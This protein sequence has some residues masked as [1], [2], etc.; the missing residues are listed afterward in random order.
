MAAGLAACSSGNADTASGAAQSFGAVAR[1]DAAVAEVDTVIVREA[2]FSHVILSNGKL[3]ARQSAELRF[4]APGTVSKVFVRNGSRLSKGD[5]VATLATYTLEARMRQCREALSR[6]SLDMQDVIIGQGYDP[7]AEVPAAVTALARTRSGYDAAEAALDLCGK[8]LEA[9]TLRAPFDG[10][11][12]NLA[13]RPHSATPASEPACLLIN[14]SGMDV[15][16][17]VLEGELAMIA[18]GDLVEVAPVSGAPAAS[19]KVVEINPLVDAGGQISVKAVIDGSRDGFL[20]GMNARVTLRGNLGSGIAV[21]KSAVVSR[22]GR[23][24]VFT[25]G[26]GNRAVWNYVT[27]G[28]ENN[29]SFVIDEGL[30]PGACVIVSGN[31]TLAHESPVVLRRRP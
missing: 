8:E 15:E 24:V 5:P 7:G 11:V 14:D 28:A 29:T 13:L 25:L 31:A 26:P 19:G 16:F 17:K 23:Q 6:A 27:T 12:A 10:V 22:S 1:D 30:E 3:H 21:P 20:D 18:P 4:D 9:A 2:E